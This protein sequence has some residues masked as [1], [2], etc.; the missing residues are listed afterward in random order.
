[1]KDAE[2][3]P[4]AIEKNGSMPP[5]ALVRAATVT[6]VPGTSEDS[7]NFWE[8]IQRRWWI[9]AG[10]GLISMIYFVNTALRQQSEYVGRF[11]LLVE[12]VNDAGLSSISGTDNNKSSNLDYDTQIQVLQSPGLLNRSVEKL[13]PFYPNLTYSN[14]IQGLSITQ[15]RDTKI[16]QV[17]YQSNNP[18]EVP[19]VLEQISKDYLAYSLNE[20]E[21]NLQQGLR[22]VQTQLISAQ[23]RVDDL[24]LKLQAFRQNNE[25][26][27]PDGKASQVISQSEQLAQQQIEVDQELQQAQAELDRLQEETGAIATLNQSAAYQQ[28]VTQLRELETLIALERTRF[29]DDS[30]TIRVLREKQSNVLA[31]LGDEARR[32]IGGRAAE[33]SNRIQILEVQQ[34]AI[35]ETQS[36]LDQQFQQIPGLSRQYTDLQRELQIA[37]ESLNRLLVTRET[38]QVEAAQKEIPWQIVEPPSQLADSVE[39]DTARSLL[40]GLAISLALGVGAAFLIEKLDS[41]FHAADDLSRRF[42]LP[43]LA[44]IPLQSDLLGMEYSVR[45]QRRKSVG[46]QLATWIKQ[47]QRSISGSVPLMPQPDD[48][49]VFEFEESF[50]LLQTNLQMMQSETQKP[51]QTIVITSAQAGD[52]KST[53]AW[54]LAQTA[55]SIGKRV[56]LVDA[57]LRRSQLQTRLNLAEKKGLAELFS[58]KPVL[59]E[60]IQQPLPGSS[61]YI[62]PSGATTLDPVQVFSSPRMRALATKLEDTFDLVI[63]DAPPLNGLADTLQ[64]AAHAD[65]LLLVVRLHKTDKAAAAKAIE[66]LSHARARLLGLVANGR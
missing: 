13:R 8:M 15:L 9:V 12:P 66:S 31:L 38:L 34:Q 3:K 21:T 24:Q 37:T 39:S 49:D 29:Q 55:A 65:S 26:F 53:I 16:I 27:D 28:L 42:K 64:L 59:K 11:R 17:Q 56:L 25:F 41:T 60:V 54:Y 2:S 36:S 63:Y 7:M 23:K 47:L 33:I 61:L 50:K 30:L 18:T 35:A 57:D 14:L 43:I 62:L 1:M 48:Y 19:A 46:R 32:A 20:R 40:L 44:V 58:A 45:S 51:I 10:V 52:G 4:I 6:Q 22:F 5:N